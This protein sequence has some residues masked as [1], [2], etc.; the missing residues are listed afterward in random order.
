MWKWAENASL[1]VVRTGPIPRHIAFIMD[2]NRRWATRSGMK[3]FE[4]H[5]F[6]LEKLLQVISW[7]LELGIGILTVFAFS[8]DN[9][10]R[11]PEEVSE[12]MR[13]F[14]QACQ[15]L[16]DSRNSVANKGVRIKI[17]G[18]IEKFTE[19]AQKALKTLEKDTEGNNLCTL[20]ICLGYG[21]IE[22]VEHAVSKCKQRAGAGEEPGL[23][24]FEDELWIKEPVDLM[25]RTG[26]TRLSNFLLYQ[27]S[28]RTK[29]LMM[30]SI[31][32]PDLKIW[33][34]LYI[35]FSYQYLL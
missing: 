4:G 12:L 32:W 28:E 13:L 10:N 9:F 18:N 7:C 31:L 6:G 26:E 34:M 2:G 21:S 8:T 3:K 27:S 11:S 16:K 22:E 23:P 5:S 35:I 20:N 24:M 1:K 29:F 33:H 19:S 30:T 17:I 15:K 14:E 25:V